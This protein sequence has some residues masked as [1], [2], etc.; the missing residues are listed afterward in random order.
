MMSKIA[1]VTLSRHEHEDILSELKV[2]AHSTRVCVC[3]HAS[4]HRSRVEPGW[5]LVRS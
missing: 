1:F 5:C 2:I 3:Q 4:T